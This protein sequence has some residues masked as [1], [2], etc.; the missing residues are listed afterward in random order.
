MK[1]HFN[2]GIE[3]VMVEDEVD[4]N[5]FLSPDKHTGFKSPDRK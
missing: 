4:E 3:E 5:P 1:M 2:Q